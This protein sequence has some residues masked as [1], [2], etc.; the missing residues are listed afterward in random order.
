MYGSKRV[1]VRDFN[2]HILCALCGGYLIQATTVI[3]CLHS[4][5]RTCIVKFLETSKVCPICDAQIHKTRPLLNIRPDQTLQSLVYKLVPGLFQDEMRRRREFHATL[6]KSDLEDL[7]LEERGEASLER[8]YKP[9]DDHVSLVLQM[10]ARSNAHEKF[11]V[12]DTRYLLCPSELTVRHLKKF[13]RCKFQLGMQHKINLFRAKEELTDELMLQDIALIYSWRRDVPMNIVYTVREIELNILNNSLSAE[14]PVVKDISGDMN[15]DKNCDLSS[16]KPSPI[17]LVQSSSIQ[18]ISTEGESLTLPN[19]SMEVSTSAAPSPPLTS[20]ASPALSSPSFFSTPAISSVPFSIFKMPSNASNVTLPSKSPIPLKESRSPVF[21]K[22]NTINSINGNCDANKRDPLFPKN[23]PVNILHKT[24]LTKSTAIN[25]EMPTNFVNS[26]FSRLSC[27]PA[28]VNNVC[29]T[30][31]TPSLVSVNNVLVNGSSIRGSPS[32]QSQI[33]ETCPQ[34]S[35]QLSKISS[36]FGH[37]SSVRCPPK[38]SHVKGHFVNAVSKNNHSLSPYLTSSQDVPLLQQNSSVSSKGSP[39][40]SQVITD[41]SR[42]MHSVHAILSKSSP[43]RHNQQTPPQSTTPLRWTPVVEPKTSATSSTSIHHLSR[44]FSVQPG[45]TQTVS[46]PGSNCS[47]RKDFGFTQCKNLPKTDVHH[48][49]QMSEGMVI[50]ATEFCSYQCGESDSTSSKTFQVKYDVGPT[51]IAQKKCD[52]PNMQKCSNNNVVNISSEFKPCHTRVLKQ[53]T[54][55]GHNSVDCESL[56]KISEDDAKPGV[57]NQ[58][59]RDAKLIRNDSTKPDAKESMHSIVKDTAKCFFNAKH[60]ISNSTSLMPEQDLKPPH[61]FIKSEPEHTLLNKMAN[62]NIRLFTESKLDV[63]VK[64]SSAK[65]CSVLEKTTCTSSASPSL[66]TPLMDSDQ[67]GSKKINVDNVGPGVKLQRLHSYSG[68][69]HVLDKS[70]TQSLA[71]QVHSVGEDAI[72]SYIPKFQRHKAMYLSKR[73][74]SCIESSNTSEV[75]TEVTCQQI[76]EKRNWKKRKL[77]TLDFDPATAGC[78][79]KEE[80]L[81]KNDSCNSEKLNS[82]IKTG[83]NDNIRNPHSKDT[84]NLKIVNNSSLG[85]TSQERCLAD[86]DIKAPI[87]DHGKF[88]QPLENSAKPIKT[89]NTLHHT[90][91]CLPMIGHFKADFKA[92]QSSNDTSRSNLSES[93]NSLIGTKLSTSSVG[94]QNHQNNKQACESKVASV[95]RSGNRKNTVFSNCSNNNTTNNNNNNNILNSELGYRQKQALGPRVSERVVPNN[96]S[97]CE[98]KLGSISSLEK[99]GISQATPG[100]YCSAH[101]SQGLHRSCSSS[102]VILDESCAGHTSC[103]SVEVP[104]NW[105]PSD[106]ASTSSS[107]TSPAADVTSPG[108]EDRTDNSVLLELQVTPNCGKSYLSSHCPEGKG[109]PLDL[110]SSKKK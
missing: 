21:E 10:V 108:T 36:Q 3:E 32:P 73:S 87:V 19:I 97:V 41:P 27:V 50:N 59:K 79:Q 17:E 83:H 49:P 22:S 54:S 98:D 51:N 88:P 92:A 63:G 85:N 1:P 70:N 80:N 53:E 61:A 72:S 86:L 99:K 12:H 77:S 102:S 23:I 67:E 35:S 107:A 90:V 56:K 93:A 43:S 94:Y 29:S 57:K 37:S 24:A 106:G 91:S 47:E 78:M 101:I 39:Q 45:G 44:P 96:R 40:V 64:L 62:A 69:I 2:P 20:P 82:G 5:C 71:S 18:E 76:M 6:P 66:N 52:I 110:S 68:Q 58:N 28:S 74:I 26:R 14:Q 13:I 15:K 34:T 65:K 95:E 46:S 55:H 104:S 4:F 105:S 81:T 60:E 31:I 48:A 9:G 75:Q 89:I 38:I 8:E 11:Q 100:S 109:L 33:Y 30:A 7:T 16:I 25:V 103:I 42:L 84:D